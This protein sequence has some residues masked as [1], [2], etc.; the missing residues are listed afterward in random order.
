MLCETPQAS[1]AKCMAPDLHRFLKSSPIRYLDPSGL[2]VWCPSDERCY[3]NDPK[4]RCSVVDWKFTHSMLTLEQVESVRGL[5]DW[6]GSEETA[7][8]LIA[9]LLAARGNPVASAQCAVDAGLDLTPGAGD[10]IQQVT[11]LLTGPNNFSG[12]ALWITFKMEKCSPRPCTTWCGLGSTVYMPDYKEKRATVR[13]DLGSQGHILFPEEMRSEKFIQMCM[14]KM[15]DRGGCS[16]LT[17][18]DPW[19]E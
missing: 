11:K 15:K 10:V 13:C 4:T 7:Q 12:G 9:C 16:S 19:A 5:A 8:R 6:T 2:I 3:G 1:F 18:D 14:D 17:E